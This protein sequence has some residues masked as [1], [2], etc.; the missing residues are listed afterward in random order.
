[1]SSPRH[2]LPLIVNCAFA[3][4]RLFFFLCCADLFALSA[5]QQEENAVFQNENV[6]DVTPTTIPIQPQE[7]QGVA[8]NLSPAPLNNVIYIVIIALA[9]MI[10]VLG[11]TAAGVCWYR[12]HTT[13]GLAKRTDYPAYGVTGP[14]PLHEQSLEPPIDV[15]L[16]KSAEVYHYNQTKKKMKAMSSESSASSRTNDPL[17]D[18]AELEI[19]DEET[20]DGEYTVYECSGFASAVDGD[21]EVHNPYFQ[22]MS[23]KTNGK[24]SY[25]VAT[26]FQT[27]AI[28][29]AAIRG[30][31]DK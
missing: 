6:G 24:F 8:H 10:G 27:N 14:N 25:P 28:Y 1:M 3:A 2:Q 21:M 31:S 12:A 7:P 13:A 15:N 17:D 18:A 9:C 30:S 11:F 29:A 19:D 23:G 4:A 26:N 20:S 16:N 22:E 5:A